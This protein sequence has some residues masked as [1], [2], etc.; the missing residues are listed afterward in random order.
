MLSWIISRLPL[1]IA[2]IIVLIL[3]YIS[4]RLKIRHKLT[5]FFYRKLH[6]L[7][8]AML[9]V[10]AFIINFVV[11]LGVG[12][13]NS[14]LQETW[15]TVTIFPLAIAIVINVT[16]SLIAVAN[17]HKYHAKQY[18]KNQKPHTKK[19]PRKATKK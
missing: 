17:I 10:W 4:A 13:A 1:I 7:S 6:F 8:P 14:I 18:R 9:Q 15:F 16:T 2:G 12:F 19:N 5:D 11:I 3:F